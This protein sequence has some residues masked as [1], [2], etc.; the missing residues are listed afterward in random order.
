MNSK[1]SRLSPLTILFFIPLIPH[2]NVIDGFV[3]T[4]DLPI[5][6]FSFFA[7][8]SFKLFPKGISQIGN[9]K[10]IFLF[11]IYL[12]LQNQIINNGFIHSEILRY[13]F[14]SFLFIYVISI[15]LNSFDQNIP[16]YLF[17]FLSSFSILS[18]FLSLNL[19]TDLYQN[20]NIGLNLSDIDYIKGRVNGFQAGGPNSFA[21]LIT[22]TAVYSMFRLKDTYL[23]Y[24]IIFSFFGCFFTYSRFSL[25]VLVLFT[26]LKIFY[27]EKKRTNLGIFIAVFLVCINFGLIERFSSD[28][29]S[30]IQDRVEMQTGTINYIFED[31][32]KNNLLGRGFDN[33]VVKGQVL[34]DA[35]KFDED[36]VSHG[37]HN[38]YLFIIL[39]YGVVGLLLYALIF[40][41]LIYKIFKHRFK[42][43]YSPY[44]YVVLAYLVLSFSSDLL[45]N[46]SVSWFLY[47]SYFLFI[48][49]TIIKRSIEN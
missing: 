46:H 40:K 31:S 29:N 22:V 42:K 39:N 7:L 47:L 41:D 23:P 33:Y 49:E 26:I 10:F 14:Y 4:D 38:S 9:N 37:P 44:F 48:K 11:I 21:D 8:F 5:L 36:N 34:Y 19:G 24:V 6:V 3:H 1:V 35:D 27:V 2:L 25:I 16:V 15:D 30:G 13:L 43:E 45:Q 20:W 17:F 18:Y 28:D 12:F 32:I